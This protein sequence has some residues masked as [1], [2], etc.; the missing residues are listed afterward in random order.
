VL[1]VGCWGSEIRNQSPTPDTQHPTPFL[2]CLA[3][4]GALAR[5]EA[6]GRALPI[7]RRAALFDPSSAK[8]R[9][10]LTDYWD[11]PAPLRDAAAAL[12]RAAGEPRVAGEMLAAA[13][14][15]E[16]LA[17]RTGEAEA[18]AR[19]A[20]REGPQLSRPHEILAQI[21][22]DASRPRQA[23]AAA[24]AG[25][26]ADE[27]SAVALA[28][29]ARALEAEGR[30]GEAL[31]AHRQAL[32]VAPAL[33]TARL[34]EA[35]LLLRAARREQALTILRT[36]VSEPGAS[37]AARGLLLEAEGKGAPAPGR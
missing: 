37:A 11:G 23:L 2:A 18:L 17:G 29:R 22:L 20:A 35:R 19:R 6:P 4:A 1:G 14:T 13:A 28:L 25:V 24:K 34:G 26:E 15:C 9:G 3:A 32:A 31:E 27:G 5:L 36:L 10:T 12:A 30:L 16:L 7:V 21:H 8:D 33:A